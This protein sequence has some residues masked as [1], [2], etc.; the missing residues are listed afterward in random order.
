MQISLI[1]N[2]LKINVI[3]FFVLNL[4]DS[5]SWCLQMF[6]DTKRQH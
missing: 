5:R 1:Y 4:N 3:K 2:K 6:T